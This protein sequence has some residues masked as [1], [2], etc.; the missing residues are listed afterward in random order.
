MTIGEGRHAGLGT[1][2]IVDDDARMRSL[3]VDL[4]TDAGFVT[5][6]ASD[7]EAAL[8]KLN[9]APNVALLL[10][11]VKLPGSMDGLQLVSLVHKFCP[12]IK[13]IAVSDEVGQCVVGL[14]RG[15]RF[16]SKPYD[17]VS[18]IFDVHSL[19]RPEASALPRSLRIDEPFRSDKRAY[20]S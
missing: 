16:V 14:P 11:D 20:M 17:A 9:S 1:I 3:A 18:L 15:S 4:L 12:Q 13:F 8:T 2:L 19:L 5:C 10:A 6:E 7:A